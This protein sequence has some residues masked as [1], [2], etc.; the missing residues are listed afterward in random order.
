MFTIPGF[1]RA[2]VGTRTLCLLHE[3]GVK[4]CPG[5]CVLSRELL[6]GEGML[7]SHEDLSMD[8]QHL[9]KSQVQWWPL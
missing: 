7:C 9:W 4:L 1:P 5:V 8:P 2:S 6:G 3:A